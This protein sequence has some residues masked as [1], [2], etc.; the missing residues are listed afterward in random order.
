MKH[1][2]FNTIIEATNIGLISA[3]KELRDMRKYYNIGAF[4]S[5]MAHLAIRCKVVLRHISILNTYNTVGMVK[6]QI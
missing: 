2:I 6:W 1:V 5:L 4:K 3:K